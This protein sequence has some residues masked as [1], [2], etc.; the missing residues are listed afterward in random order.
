MGDRPDRRSFADSRQARLLAFAVFVACL[1]LL[2]YMHREDLW[3]AEIDEAA[4]LNPEFIACRDARTVTLDEM[5]SE[6]LIDADR[7]AQFTGRAVAIC[8]SE[9]PMGGQ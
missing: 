6:G 9:F 8:A 5:L 7:H 1:A 2:V 4:G 3:P